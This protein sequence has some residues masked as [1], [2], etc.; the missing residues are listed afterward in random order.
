ME[1]QWTAKT[2]VLGILD[3]GRPDDLR[4][5]SGRNELVPIHGSM[6][7]WL[8]C[9]MRSDAANHN[10]PENHVLISCILAMGNPSSSMLGLITASLYMGGFAASL[11]AAV[12]SDRFGRRVVLQAGLGLELLGSILQAAAPGRAVFIAGR[13]VVGI[14]MSFATVAG[15]SLLAE[16]LPP[17]L[18]GKIAPSVSRVLVMSFHRSL[19]GCFSENRSTMRCGTLDRSSPPG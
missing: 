5:R 7:E 12:P 15:P 3:P 10:G 8:V 19:T 1:G 17:R 18:R 9:S 16:L 13:V 14:G 4:V 6:A 11:F 2:R